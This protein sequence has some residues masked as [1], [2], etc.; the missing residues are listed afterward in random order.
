VCDRISTKVKL[1]PCQKRSY[2]NVGQGHGNLSV[3]RYIEDANVLIKKLT[4]ESQAAIARAEQTGNYS[5]ISFIV[6]RK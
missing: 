3:P 2:V 6:P 5:K 4:Q 1:S